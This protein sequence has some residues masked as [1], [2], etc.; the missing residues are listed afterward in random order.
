MYFAFFLKKKIFG[1]ESKFTLQPE[2]VQASIIFLKGK[3]CFLNNNMTPEG[4]TSKFSIANLA[5]LA[6]I[7]VGSP[8]ERLLM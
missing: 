3:L 6:Q 1:F 5:W 8:H 2:G 7:P 4:G